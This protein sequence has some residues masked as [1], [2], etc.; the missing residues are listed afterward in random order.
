V[1]LNARVELEATLSRAEAEDQLTQKV[2]DPQRVVDAIKSLDE[3]LDQG[4]PTLTNIELAKHIDRIVCGAD[5]TVRLRGTYLGLFEGAVFLLNEPGT[6]NQGA[7]EEPRPGQVRQRRLA[8]RQSPSLSS[9]SNAV[10][11]DVQFSA[12]PNRFADLAAEF[13]WS[14]S[15]EPLRP[16]C[17]EHAAEVLQA[18]ESQTRGNKSALAIQFGKSVPTIRQALKFA[19]EEREKRPS[20]GDDNANATRIP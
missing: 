13:F 20:H 16:W 2:F 15:I 6:P 5:G 8:P 1:A 12:D 14:E 17:Q 11:A 19:L 9:E 7:E 10:P 4:N 18:F 3:L